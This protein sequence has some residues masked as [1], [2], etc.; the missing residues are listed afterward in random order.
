[1]KV[2]L[3]GATGALGVPLVRR[4]IAAGHEVIGITRTEDGLRGDVDFPAVSERARLITPVHG[5]VG[6][7]RGPQPLLPVRQRLAREAGIQFQAQCIVLGDAALA[8]I[9]TWIIPQLRRLQRGA[10]RC[11]GAGKLDS[12]VSPARSARGDTR[13]SMRTA[14]TMVKALTTT[15]SP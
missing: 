3:A 7:I 9:E 10:R 15:L 12:I 5:G 14:Q 1:M 13:P 2:L 11:P 8:R 6:H 4:L